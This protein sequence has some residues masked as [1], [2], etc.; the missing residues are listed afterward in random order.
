MK[1]YELVKF[2]AGQHFEPQFCGPLTPLSVTNKHRQ[3]MWSSLKPVEMY[4]LRVSLFET[5]VD[6]IHY[7]PTLI[8]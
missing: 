8:K 2:Q 7:Q 4:L 3:K 5:P 6:S 1:Y